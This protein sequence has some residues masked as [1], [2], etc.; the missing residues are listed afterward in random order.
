MDFSLLADVRDQLNRQYGG[1]S[2]FD[3]AGVAADEP[4]GSQ[5]VLVIT[6]I[7]D[8]TAAAAKDKAIPNA[9]G[10]VRVRVKHPLLKVPAP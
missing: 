10:D 2:W 3:A 5:Y 1:E 8:P 4:G 7:E 9:I 6:R